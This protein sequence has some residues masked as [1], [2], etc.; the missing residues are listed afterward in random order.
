[1]VTDLRMSIILDVCSTKK[2]DLM[3]K[4]HAFIF[5]YSYTISWGDGVGHETDDYSN[6]FALWEAFEKL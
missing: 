1:M 2:R 5:F 4:I 6:I 3:V